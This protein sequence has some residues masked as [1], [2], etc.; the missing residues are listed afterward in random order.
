M[1]KLYEIQNHYDYW[2]VVE[3]GISGDTLIA[4]TYEKESADHIM[5][6]LELSDLLKIEN[7]HDL[8]AQADELESALQSSVDDDFPWVMQLYTKWRNISRIVRRKF[9]DMSYTG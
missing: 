1:R 9:S 4:K 7:Y 5:F 6:L 3:L 2:A 8:L